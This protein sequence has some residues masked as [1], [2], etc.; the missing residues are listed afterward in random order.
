MHVISAIFRRNFISY[1]S[2]PTGYVFICV[3]TLLSGIAAFWTP[4]F[5]NAKLANLDQLSFWFPSVMLIFVPAITMS[6]WAEERRQGTD[7]L[8]LTIPATDGQVVC[9]KYLAAVAIFTVGLAFSFICNLLVL[10]GLGNPDTGVFATTYIGYWFIGCMMLSIGTAASFLT[11]NLT[12]AYVLGAMLNTPLVMLAWVDG[13]PHIGPSL[14]SWSVADR[15]ADFGRG[16]ISVSSLSYFLGFTIVGLYACVVLIGRRH[17]LG[18]RDGESL[19]AHY[20]ARGISLCAVVLGLQIFFVNHDPVRA[21]LSSE[22]LSTLSSSTVKLLKGLDAKKAVKIEAFVSTAA[23]T[24]ES[25]QTTRLNLLSTLNEIRAAAGDR[26][27]LQVHEVKKISDEA[28]RAD[29]QYGIKPQQVTTTTGGVRRTDEDDVIL[30]LAFTC[31]RKN[32]VVPFV[33][34]MLP[35]EYEIVRS[36]LAVSDAKKKKIGIVLTDARLD[37][38]GGD[39]GPGV[40][41]ELKKQYDIVDIDANQPITEKVDALIALQPS[42]L[43]PPAFDNFVA[44]VKTGIPTAIFEDP[45]ALIYSVPGTAQPKQP[46]QSNPFMGMQPPQPKGNIQSLWDALEVDF[47]SSN[48]VWQDYDAKPKLALPM[49][50]Q[51]RKEWVY[52]GTGSGA[53]DAFNTKDSISSG[54]QLLLIPFPGSIEHLRNAKATEFTPLIRTSKRSGTVPADRIIQTTPFGRMPN[55]NLPD[56]EKFKGESFVLAARIQGKKAPVDPKMSDKDYVGDTRIALADDKGADK[57]AADKADENVAKPAAKAETKP[58]NVV[59]VADVDMFSQPFFYIRNRGI[60]FL[61][62]VE[63]DVDNVTFVMNTIDSLAGDDRLIDVRNRRRI[64]RTLTKIEE[65]IAASVDDSTK[66]REETQKQLNKELEA[67]QKKFDAKVKAIEEDKNLKEDAKAVQVMAA[68]Q[69][70]ERRLE[71]VRT[72]LG[73]QREEKTRQSENER[74]LQIRNIQDQYK[75]WAICLPP[76]L[77]LIVAFAVFFIRKSGETEGVIAERLR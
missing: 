12:V 3:F 70:S 73:Q 29:Q 53:E 16:V 35:A 57:K 49:G 44:A 7:E 72:K 38:G 47:S 64:Y 33:G 48:V 52:A 15:F 32:L 20:L 27:D 36:I 41:D 76:M 40:K 23:E 37:G 54:L 43:S 65:Q 31:G 63:L 51:A 5:W 22:G 18:G 39:D 46:P 62:D 60:E 71:V 68:K 10:K 74:K 13:I 69:N 14:K 42:T 8:L 1:F 55:R 2:N 45:F 28:A 56:D 11:N 21:D 9:G 34:K 67:E 58:L 25:Y 75:S 17:W 24:P 26:V 59:L 6:I 30:G 66:L 4:A 77:P 19:L 61:E 50:K